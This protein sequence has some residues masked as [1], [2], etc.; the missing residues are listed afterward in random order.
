MNYYIGL[1]FGTTNSIISYF[2]NNEVYTYKYGFPGSQEEYIPSFIAYEENSPEIGSSARATA[3]NNPNVESYGNFKMQL[4][5]ESEIDHNGNSHHVFE[6]TTDYLRQLLFS[7]DNSFSFARQK[8]EIEGLVVSVPEIWQRDIRNIGRERL[9]KIIEEK[10]ELPL[11]QLVSEPVA[12]ASYYAWKAQ[13]DQ[14]KLLLVCDVGGGTFDV[15]ICRIDGN[16]NIEVLYFDGEG[17]QGLE[18]AGVAFD[19]R[20]VETAYKKGKKEN[21]PEIKKGDA[22][23]SR[24]LKDFEQ[25]KLYFH[26]KATNRIK[27]YLRDQESY[28]ARDV[29]Y[30]SDY[31]INCQEVVE[32]FAPIKARIQDVITRVNQWLEETDYNLDQVFMVGGFS[33]FFLVQKAISEALGIEDNDQRIDRSANLETSAYAISYGACLIANREVDPIE[34]YEHTLGF[35]AHRSEDY[36]EEKVTLIEGKTVALDNLTEPYFS[37]RLVTAIQNKIYIK[38]WVDPQ[39]RGCRHQE[40][41][42]EPISLPNFSSKAVYKVG[43][44]VDRSQICYLVLQE[45]DSKAT[46]EHELGDIIKKMFPA[47]LFIA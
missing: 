17:Y 21:E 26:D 41:I 4:P 3:T 45:Q 35:V 10:L 12:A 29:Y 32:A 44:R 31:S 6:V 24:L 2:E 42:N 34:K 14:E 15:S 1:D 47:G 9:K 28:A 11:I 22:R 20:C 13:G 33:Q 38:L 40:T 36:Q 37:D 39:S 19:S 16:N 5:T 8:G 30:F 25:A 46:I 7:E 18:T 43:M 23:F 27:N